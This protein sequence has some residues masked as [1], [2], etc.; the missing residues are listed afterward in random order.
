MTAVDHSATP[1]ATSSATARRSRRGPGRAV[2]GTVASVVLLVV[3][4]LASLFVGARTVDPTVVWSVLTA[5]PGR[6]LSGDLAAALAPGSD[7]MMDEVVVAAR[8]PRTL[9]AILVGVA[10]FV[11][12][13]LCFV[14]GLVVMFFTWF[15]LYFVVDKNMPALEAIK[16]SVSFV[17]K[18]MGTLIGFFLA[19][20]VAYFVGALLCGI[21]LLVA[22][23]VVIIAQ[24]YTYRT[25]Q[26]EEVAA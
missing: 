4:V 20:L 8:V 2:V 11:G 3:A 21:G 7:A 19:A 23:P 12:L 16:A 24:A 10:T 22:I 9:A 15:T 5:L 6:V 26:G 14:P 25:L 18:N 1:R 13:L 17:N